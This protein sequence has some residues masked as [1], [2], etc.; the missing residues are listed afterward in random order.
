MRYS[1]I[2]LAL[3][4]AVFATIPTLEAD[5]GATTLRITDGT[6]LDP[7]T[8]N[9][10][11]AFGA[12]GGAG[13][14][15][16]DG[17][18]TA[19]VDTFITEIIADAMYLIL[20]DIDFGDGSTST[21]FTSLNEQLYFVD[22]ALPFIAANA[23]FDMG[24]ALGDWSKNGSCMSI[25][26]TGGAGHSISTS[27]SAVFATYGS[28]IIRR[29]A[30]NYSTLALSGGTWIARNFTYIGFGLD[31]IHLSTG[32]VDWDTVTI[33]DPFIFQMS[34]TPTNFNNIHVH[35]AY[36]G[37]F[38]YQPITATNMLITDA[39]IEVQMNVAGNL[40]LK[41]PRFNI[42]GSK[43]TITNA[44]GNIIEQYTCNIHVND[45][46]GVDLEGASVLCEDEADAEVF[47]VSTDVNGDIAE[48]LINYKQWVGTD[49]TLT[50]FSPH[51]FTISKADLVTLV[52]DAVTV[53]D[54]I[55]FLYEQLLE[56]ASG[57]GGIRSRYNP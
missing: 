6:S 25:G 3:C 27:A 52:I 12:G 40:I 20:K 18:G 7:V 43:V 5:A 38:S 44:S 24:E 31:Y 53:D 50:D 33:L 47:S 56:S 21:Y 11:W 36:T 34:L 8:W 19:R 37:L 22:D 49:E 28:M 23:R 26:I 55:S 13:L 17:G 48:Q 57:G 46:D 45:K 15:P 39:S 35:G 42:N 4:G 16:L 30:S 32:T 9:D 51:V 1:F 10:V 29:N 14:V 41:N 54:P 2:F